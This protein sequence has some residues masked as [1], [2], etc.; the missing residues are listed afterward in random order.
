MVIKLRK[1]LCMDSSRAFI[2]W[3]FLISIIGMVCILIWGSDK[4]SIM[5]GNIIRQIWFSTYGVQFL[6]IMLMGAIPYAGAMCEDME[7]GYIRQLVLRGNLLS[8]CISKAVT[9]FMSA[10]MSFV[11]GI[12]IFVIILKRQNDWFDI[13][14]Y[15][16]IAA[17]RSG[18]FR[19]CIANEQYFTYI[20]LFAVQLGML[21]GLLAIL[22]AYISLYISNKLLVLS[23]PIMA[24]YFITQY[25]VEMF[26]KSKY[27]NINMIYTGTANIFDN[28]ILSF[29]YT[30]VVTVILGGGLTYMIYCRLKSINS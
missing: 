28:D 27:T 7:Y 6:I 18:S 17:A 4:D 29:L 14:D 5:D 20:V 21:I 16:C 10:L 19:V 11:L 26:P 8:Y 24:Y 15:V 13:T 23:I 9:I 25:I 3:N 12:I 22:S 1:Y 30:I 2:S